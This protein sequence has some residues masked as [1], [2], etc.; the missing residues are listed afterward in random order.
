MDVCG[1]EYGLLGCGDIDFG[2][3]C[4]DLVSGVYPMAEWVST[5][6]L[7]YNVR[8]KLGCVVVVGYTK[9]K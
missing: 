6:W 8:Q 9:E 5:F 1:N 7:W 4:K 2:G 3:Y